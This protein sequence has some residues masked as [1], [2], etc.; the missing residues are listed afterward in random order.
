MRVYVDSA[1]HRWKGQSW[2]HVFSPDIDALHE[3][4]LRVGSKR[5]WFQNPRTMPKVSWPHYDANERRRAKL[6][7]AGAVELGRH[8]TIAMAGVVRNVWNGTSLDALALHRRIRSS[9]TERLAS[10]LERELTIL[11]IDPSIHL[12]G[13]MGERLTDCEMTATGPN[14]GRK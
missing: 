13:R 6:L 3:M 7:S 4:M 9:Q 5:E 1:I 12:T 11:G 8:Q 2:C 10:W 14:R